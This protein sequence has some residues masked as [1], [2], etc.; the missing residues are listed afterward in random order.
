[1]LYF[2]K[3][4]DQCTGCAACANICPV[5][6]IRMIS[7]AEGFEYPSADLDICI[8]CGK[9]EKTCPA[10]TPDLQKNK[11]SHQESYAAIIND[12]KIWS[13]SSSGGA[14]TAICQ[15][16]ADNQ[17]SLFVFGCEIDSDKI[18]KHSY[19]Q[20][21]KNINKY[22]HSKYVQSRIG[23][24]YRDLKKLLLDQK[25]VVF[26][27]TP[28][29]VA[30]LTAYL[31]NKQYDNLLKVD[32]ICHGVGSPLVFDKYLNDLKVKFKTDDITYSF[33]NKMLQNNE[34]HIY[35][36]KIIHGSKKTYIEKDAYNTLFLNQLCLRPSCSTNC[37]YRTIERT[38]DITIADFK[39]LNSI[40]PNMQSDYKNYSTVV[41]NTSQGQ[42]YKE[43]LMQIMQLL[44][45]SIKDIKSW[46]PLIY[47]TTPGNP[48]RN[49][50]F[51]DFEHGY[52]IPYLLKK[53]THKD[54][55]KNRLSAFIKNLLYHKYYFQ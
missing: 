20:G 39:G 35:V 29:Q 13:Q 48:N 44:P 8:N 34:L 12:N 27:G 14:F 31:G 2:L 7:D 1:M 41:F 38:G 21:I 53:Y 33:R 30:G 42:K 40:F 18:I 49:R 22:R 37:Q 5:S 50:F 11:S 19:V 17:D 6:C 32:F 54:P 23:L 9:C 45:C 43:R 26:V 52:S 28:C 25:K 24:C 46:N 47:K 36:S 51:E 15:A 55:I 10:L 16:F 4:K 3:N